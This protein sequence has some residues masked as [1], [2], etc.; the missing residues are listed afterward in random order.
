MLDF[1]NRRILARPGIRP[2][3]LFIRELIEYIKHL[4]RKTGGI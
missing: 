2:L 3:R 4:H 1:N